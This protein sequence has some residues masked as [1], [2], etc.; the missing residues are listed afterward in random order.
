ML[1]GST[2]SNASLKSVKLWKGTR[3]V[4]TAG[5]ACFQGRP[6]GHNLDR[7]ADQG[8]GASAARAE[9]SWVV[10]MALEVDRDSWAQWRAVGRQQQLATDGQIAT[11]LLHQWVSPALF[12]R[13][14]SHASKA[15]AMD[16]VYCL[17]LFFLKIIKPRLVDAGGRLKSDLWLQNCI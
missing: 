14:S 5:C 6:C 3:W 1:Y 16:Q 2:L 11:F 15:G 7:G 9:V 17:A 13:P 10:P 8:S 12:A 4:F